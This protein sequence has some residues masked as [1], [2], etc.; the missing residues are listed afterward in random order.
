M[1]NRK[2]LSLILILLF[3]VW[4][5]AQRDSSA[6]HSK[7]IL[8][9]HPIFQAAGYTT[10]VNSVLIGIRVGAEGR[11][12][13]DLWNNRYR[14]GAS[15]KVFWEDGAG[16][17]PNWSYFIGLYNQYNFLHKK[18]NRLYLELGFHHSNFCLNRY[19][20]FSIETVPTPHQLYLS[21]G[22]GWDIF[23][24]PHWSFRLAYKGH[25]LLNNPTVIQPFWGQDVVA[26][27]TY[28]FY[29]RPRRANLVKRRAERRARKK[30]AHAIPTE[31]GA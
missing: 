23:L 1:N 6:W 26:G 28:H 22:G 21:F 11:Y 12:G 5:I 16:A 7:S 9:L 27:I 31:L 18:H 20:T 13:I 24:H 14:V 4:L 10:P 25:L 2:P 30:N 8:T 17:T 15:T 3:P 29:K 19:S